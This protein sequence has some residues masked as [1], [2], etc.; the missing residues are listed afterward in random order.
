MDSDTYSVF[1]NEESQLSRHTITP[2][3]LPSAHQAI[4]KTT[5]TLTTLTT[6]SLARTAHC[7]RANIMAYPPPPP[8]QQQTVVEHGREPCPDRI[9]D[10]IGGAFG[11]GA[12][13][14]GL[15]HTYR[16]LKNSP[17]GYKMIGTLEV[18]SAPP[19]IGAC[20]H[21]QRLRRVAAASRC[22]G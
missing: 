9:L 2:I 11:M 10:D 12:I 14:G 1:V 20:R 22:P 18:G 5:I 4:G 6:Y 16:G 13:G 3:I 15:W 17:R 7:L 8:Q 21:H 19:A